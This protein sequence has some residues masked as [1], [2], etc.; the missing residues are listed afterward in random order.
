MNRQDSSGS[1]GPSSSARPILSRS[2]AAKSDSSRFHGFDRDGNVSMTG[3][4]DDRDG[5]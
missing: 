4:E 3:D 2:M 5:K 1:L